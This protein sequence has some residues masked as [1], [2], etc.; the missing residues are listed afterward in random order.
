[1]SNSKTSRDGQKNN[2]QII[3]SSKPQATEQG[4]KEKIQ[5]L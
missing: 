2:Q 5:E 1:M 3:P 4:Y